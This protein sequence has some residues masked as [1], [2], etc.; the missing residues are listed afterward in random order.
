MRMKDMKRR[1]DM[2]KM[3]QKSEITGIWKMQIELYLFV[4]LSSVTVHAS[5]DKRKRAHLYVK[6]CMRKKGERKIT[7]VFF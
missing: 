1:G 3:K 4:S 5:A 2:C 7:N 6:L